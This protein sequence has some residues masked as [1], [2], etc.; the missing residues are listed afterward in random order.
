MRIN[1]FLLSFLCFLKTLVIYPID[2]PLAFTV[3]DGRVGNNVHVY[4]YQMYF[5][6]KKKIRPFFR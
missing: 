6:M 4:I 1:F 5:Q 2:K 3:Y